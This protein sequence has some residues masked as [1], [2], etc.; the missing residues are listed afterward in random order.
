M[1]IDC[2]HCGPRGS[3]EFTYFT[4]ADRSR[5]AADAPFADW[6][7]YVHLRDNPHGEHREHWQ[8]VHGCRRW[9]TVTRNTRTHE[10][11]AVEDAVPFRGAA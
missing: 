2:P 8:H 1:R 6:H 10:I 4:A 3:E 5:P 9:L 11:V 7:E